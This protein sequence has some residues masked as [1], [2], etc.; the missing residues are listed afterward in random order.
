MMQPEEIPFVGPLLVAGADDS[1]FDAFLI[2]GPAVITVIAILGRTPTS[3]V[4]A[5][6]YTGG[7]AGYIAYKGLLGTTERKT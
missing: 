3:I 5:L 4:L 7:F 2:M 6:V 1:V